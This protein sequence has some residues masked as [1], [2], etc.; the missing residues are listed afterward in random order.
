MFWVLIEHSF[1]YAQELTGDYK[2]ENVKHF[3]N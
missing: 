2:N 3:I 1:L